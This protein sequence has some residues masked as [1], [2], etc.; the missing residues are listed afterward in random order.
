M[1]KIPNR[2]C[3]AECTSTRYFLRR[4][5]FLGSHNRSLG[6]YL[7]AAIKGVPLVQ[8]DAEGFR[9]T[10][11]NYSMRT[12]QGTIL[13]VGD[14]TTFCAEVNNHETVASRCAEWLRG[15]WHTIN[16]GVRGYSTL[17][18]LRMLSL[19]LP[20]LVPPVVVV[21]LL[22]DNDIV[23]NCHPAMHW[24]AMSPYV[25]LENDAATINEV[26]DWYSKSQEIIPR[27]TSS[28][29]WTRIKLYRTLA[30]SSFSALLPL[31]M[32]GRLAAR[33]SCN[34]RGLIPDT[35]PDKATT[36]FHDI[37]RW[38]LGRGSVEILRLLVGQMKELC[39]KRNARFI[40]VPYATSN[41]AW[42]PDFVQ[43]RI[44]HSS[45]NV[46]DPRPY[47]RACGSDIR[48]TT[49]SGESDMHLGLDGGILYGRFLAKEVAR[50]I[51]GVYRR[52]PSCTP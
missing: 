34:I 11:P 47:I 20:Q 37:A 28:D 3:A 48:A 10:E 14:S 33:A 26:P 7:N 24:P 38:A 18:A 44:A 50:L 39:E 45:C 40:L 15:R 6:S 52:R 46:I 49:S 16:A 32:R 8:T 9:I 30:W 42:W 17:Q 12:A 43:K 2:R 31:S 21:F 51:P 5:P 4:H 23:E 27:P 13:F 22:T 41:A 1:R 25:S 36:S 35:I 19:I 29:E